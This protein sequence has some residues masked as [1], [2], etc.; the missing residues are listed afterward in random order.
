[1]A[2]NNLSG[3]P[4]TTSIL[5]L[6]GETPRQQATM[7]KQILETA[8]CGIAFVSKEQELRWMNSKFERCF[9]YGKKEMVGMSVED[10]VP[11]RF[12]KKQAKGQ[13]GYLKAPFTRFLGTGKAFLGLCRDE[14]ETLLD[15]GFS[16][17]SCNPEYGTTTWVIPIM[18]QGSQTLFSQLIEEVLEN[19]S[20]LIFVVGKNYSVQYVNRA[21]ELAQ[22]V[23]RQDMVGKTVI[24]LIGKDVFHDSMG[25]Y[26]NLSFKGETLRYYEKIAFKGIESRAMEMTYLPIYAVGGEVEF[27][28]V[29]AGHLDDNRKKMEQL[30]IQGLLSMPKSMSAKKEKSSAKALLDENSMQ[31]RILA[32]SVSQRAVLTLVS[33]GKT[34]K[35]IAEIL[36]LNEK[37]IRNNLTVVFRAL[38]VS[39]RAEA[40]AVFIR[41]A[42]PLKNVISNKF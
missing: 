7:L 40:V 26:L 11:P 31:Q 35:E 21:F 6:M 13:K 36:D 10:L 28:V 24:D 23:S 33:Q 12:R 29:I 16:P 2:E 1:M 17:V 41:L 32:L 18:P 20:E 34:N 3:E 15:I 5:P 25:S 8:P 4:E 38:G 14:T 27:V 30:F 22:N 42:L 9:G 37:T 39:R 19:A